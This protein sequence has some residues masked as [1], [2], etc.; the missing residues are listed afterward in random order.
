METPTSKSQPDSAPA[1]TPVQASSYT[2]FLVAI[3][4]WLAATFPAWLNMAGDWWNDPNYSHGLLILPLAIFFAWRSRE[5]WRT[6]PVRSS[7]AGLTF[8]TGA[9]A[10]YLVGTAAA[11]H[12]TV[13]FAAVAGIG[14]LAWGL[15]GWRFV[16]TVWFPLV[17]LFFAIP[18]PYVIYYKLTFPMQIFSTR[19]ACFLLD[20]LGMTIARQGNIIHLPNYSLEVVDAC[21]GVRSV[22]SLST[23]GAVYAY[24]TQR[25]YWRPWLLFALS[26]PVALGANIFRLVITA[27]GA[28]AWDPKFAEDFLHEFSGLLV[29]AVALVTFFI[30]GSIISWTDAKLRPSSR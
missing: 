15:L 21:S 18:W 27:I 7:L 16:R 13:R 23:L 6:A 4:V 22:L 26:I 20:G 29:F 11:E 28:Y 24:L 19:A 12:F 17:L 3:A 25:G 14:T 5:A 8:F 9:A 1:A 10:L 2:Y 30:L